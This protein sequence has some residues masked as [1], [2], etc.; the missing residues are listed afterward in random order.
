MTKG[1]ALAPLDG[2]AT[3]E[4]VLPWATRIAGAL[5]LKLVLLKLVPE[6]WPGDTE[7]GRAELR[8][9]RHYLHGV[10]ASISG[11]GIEIAVEAR[12]AAVAD[13]IAAGI[14]EQATA[15][16]ASLIMLATHGRRGPKRWLLGSVADAVTRTADVPVLAVRADVPPPP[17]AIDRVLVP[18]DGSTLSTASLPLATRLATALGASLDLVQVMPWAINAF[19]GVAESY[20]PPEL[21]EE[22]ANGAEDYLAAVRATLPERLGVEMHVLRGDAAGEVLDYAHQSRA[23]LIVMTTHGRSGVGRWALGSVADKILRAGDVPVL[24]VRTRASTDDRQADAAAGTHAAP[25]R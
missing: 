7:R 25:T 24:L 11:D 18:L 19:V 23:P 14:V 20:V 1:I 17:R 10:A 4:R 13:D 12:A 2:S 22:L 21:D 5:G 9:A 8:A 3:G 6:A 16:G 15:L